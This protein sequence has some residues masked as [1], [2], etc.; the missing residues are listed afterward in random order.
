MRERRS[1]N[2]ATGKGSEEKTVLGKSLERQLAMQEVGLWLLD[3]II[4]EMRQE[5]EVAVTSEDSK[6]NERLCGQGNFSKS[7][8][9]EVF[10]TYKSIREKRKKIIFILRELKDEV[11]GLREIMDHQQQQHRDRK[12]DDDSQHWVEGIVGVKAFMKLIE[13]F[14]IEEEEQEKEEDLGTII[15]KLGSLGLIRLREP[16]GREND[17]LKLKDNEEEGEENNSENESSII[18]HFDK[19]KS[20]RS[21]GKSQKGSS[22]FKGSNPSKTNNSNMTSSRTGERNINDE[23]QIRQLTMKKRNEHLDEGNSKELDDD[24]SNC[25]DADERSNGVR[26]GISEILYNRWLEG[27]KRNI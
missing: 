8:E 2:F 11:I 6:N 16:E 15:K 14:N 13:S 22:D 5:T 23:N 9:G 25:E 24:G 4:I 18:D 19:F 17:D 20:E 27:L 12:I 3:Q 26:S 1:D 7:E 21:N 10:A